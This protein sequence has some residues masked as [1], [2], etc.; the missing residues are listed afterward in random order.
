[1]PPK[2]GKTQKGKS[3]IRIGQSRISTATSAKNIK[4]LTPTNFTAALKPSIDVSE[5]GPLACPTNPSATMEL[6]N[7]SYGVFPTT[8]N[9]AIS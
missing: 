2:T 6:Q 3:P 1:M 9:S 7:P 5:Q 8:L 4:V